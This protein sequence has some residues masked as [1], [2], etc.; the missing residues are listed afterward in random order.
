M[1]QKSLF[2]RTALASTFAALG[3]I[4]SGSALAVEKLTVSGNKVLV[5]GKVDARAIEGISLFWSNNGWGGE[6]FYTAADVKRMKDEFGAKLVR[7]AVGHG[8]AGGIQDDWDGNL[9]KMDTVIQAAIDNDMY[10]IVDYH[11]H[12]AHTNWES[13]KDFFAYVANKWGGYDNVIYEIY[14]E[15][16]AVDWHSTLKPYAEDVGNFI[17]SIDPD[18]LIVMG[19]PNWS[20]DVDIASTNPANVSN[21]AYVV[22][23]YANTHRGDKRAKAQTAL[24]NGIALFATEWGMTDADGAG[25]INYDETWAWID[26]LRANGIGSAMW[27]YNDKEYSTEIPG[28]VEM[29]SMF[30]ADGT[31]KESAH[32]LKEILGGGP[33]G[34]DCTIVDGPADLLVAPGSVQAE[35]F[36]QACGIETEPTQDVGGGENIGFVDDGDWLTY[37]IDMPQAGTATVTYRVAS[38]VGGGVIRLEQAGGDVEYGTV[39]VPNTGGWQTWVDVSHQV[40]LPAGN[41]LVGVAAQTGGWNLNK[42]TITTDTTCTSNCGG[43]GVKVEAESF[44][45]AD[46]VETEATQDNGG[47]Q[48]VGW[49]DAGDWMTYNVNLPASSSGQY[50]VSYRIASDSAGGSLSLE[51][52]GGAVQ[53][54]SISFG[55]T[56]GWQNWQTVSHTV[57][58][59]AGTTQL[60]IAATTGGWNFNWF[61]IKAVDGSTTQPTGSSCDGVAVYPNWQRND[62]PGGANTHQDAGDQMVFAGNLYTA[63]WYTSSEPGSDASWTLVGSC[64]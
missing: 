60:A 41:Q 43:S 45:Q 53:Y 7:A 26:F 51:Q 13:A 31:Y 16:L 64:Q 29:S 25:A 8:A 55:A 35:A 4:A 63:N 14:N 9:A 36:A 56:G 11:S 34:G 23:F 49:I 48:N 59:P 12:K 38:D 46:G 22:H 27:S 61:E 54:G 10:V 42:I 50:E 3:L 15:P 52:P 37:N 30:W 24:N 44:A 18:N 20:Q 39:T 58:I 19:T 17:R 33:G 21:M 1:K 57:S 6:K 62:V 32:F 40:Q 28:K 47:G 2:T 5:G